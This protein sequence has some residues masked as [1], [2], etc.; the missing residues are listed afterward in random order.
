M[1][2]PVPGFLPG[3][4]RPA[5]HRV[6]YDQT[7][8]GFW[9]SEALLVPAF[10]PLPLHRRLQSHHLYGPGMVW[11]GSVVQLRAER[12][13]L[14]GAEAAEREKFWGVFWKLRRSQS[15]GKLRSLCEL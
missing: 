2:E 6:P 4:S 1:Q 12:V 7:E 11:V 13:G 3:R 10:P 5:V 8:I 15:C 14:G 9:V